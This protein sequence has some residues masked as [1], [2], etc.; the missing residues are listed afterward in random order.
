[1]QSVDLLELA[2][3]ELIGRWVAIDSRGDRSA[4]RDGRLRSLS[5]GALL[6]DHDAEL[7]ALCVRVAEAG[8]KNLDIFL[9]NHRGQA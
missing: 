5:S 3:L 2:D 8:H 9:C 7:D 6:V 1:M 4:H